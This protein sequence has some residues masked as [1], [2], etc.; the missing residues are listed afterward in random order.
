MLA[1]GRAMMS[2]PRLLLMDEPSMGLAPALVDQVFEII[3]GIHASGTAIFLVEQNARMAL[4]VSSR[5]YVLQQGTILAS[6][7][8]EDLLGSDVVREAYLGG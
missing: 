2:R 7:S 5:G 3:A 8:S 1:I 6:G 4:E